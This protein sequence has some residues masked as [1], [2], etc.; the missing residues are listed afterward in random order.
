MHCE[1][2]E[3]FKDETCTIGYFSQL[4][5]NWIAHNRAGFFNGFELYV[6]L[7]LIR[8]IYF[9]SKSWFCCSACIGINISFKGRNL[10]IF[11]SFTVKLK[12]DMCHICFTVFLNVHEQITFNIYTFWYPRA[13]LLVVCLQILHKNSV[14]LFRQSKLCIFKQQ[15]FL[16]K[17]QSLHWTASCYKLW[18]T[19]RKL[20]NP[21]INVYMVFHRCSVFLCRQQKV[22]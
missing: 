5:W 16:I 18:Y 11:Q 17:N 4:T 19:L 14:L 22:Y 1:S 13:F 10:Y 21:I 20:E 12:L 2:T 6:K 3:S 7:E 15:F 9:G 8:S